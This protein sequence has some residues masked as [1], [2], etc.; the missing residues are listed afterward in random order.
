MAKTEQKEKINRWYK[1]KT[2][3]LTQNIKYDDIVDRS[4]FRT[5]AETK[6]DAIA[7]G[8]IGAGEKGIYDYEAGQEIPKGKERITEIELLLRNNKLDKA[9][10][11]KLK[12]LFDQKANKDITT[13]SEKQALE[14]ENQAAKNRTAALDKMLGT[15]QNES[16]E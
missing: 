13:E 15:N 12:E 9:D 8:K 6:R 3:Y 1:P 7:V 16:T 10:V 2:N 14:A 5:T 11:Q 4:N